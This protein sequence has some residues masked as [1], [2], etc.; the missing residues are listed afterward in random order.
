MTHYATPYLFRRAC[1]H[2]VKAGG[3]LVPGPAT[4]QCGQRC[5]RI[6]YAH[7]LFQTRMH[8]NSDSDA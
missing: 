5:D 4:E 3:I 6:R 1:F 7:I 8:A 2:V